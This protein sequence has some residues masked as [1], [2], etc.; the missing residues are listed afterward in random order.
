MTAQTRR[1]PTRNGTLPQAWFG[2]WARLAEREE[3]AY[4]FRNHPQF[5]KAQRVYA[6]RR[7][8]AEAPATLDAMP[9]KLG[10]RD[11]EQVGRYDEDGYDGLD[12][13]RSGTWLLGSATAL[14]CSGW[15]GPTT[16]LNQSIRLMSRS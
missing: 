7:Q 15:S 4:S 6:R 16:P 5:G 9:P 12:R 11:R 8:Q 3:A 13:T 10:R 1:Q 14:S 2:R